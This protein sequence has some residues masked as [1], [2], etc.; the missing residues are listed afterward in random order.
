MPADKL[1]P[2]VP[3]P[4]PAN[5]SPVAFSSTFISMILFVLLFTP[6]PPPLIYLVISSLPSFVTYPYLHTWDENIYICTIN[7]ISCFS[8]CSSTHRRN[9][10]QSSETRTYPFL[11]L[12]RHVLSLSSKEARNRTKH[13]QVLGAYSYVDLDRETSFQSIN[14]QLH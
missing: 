12:P 9:W 3:V 10:T 8:S 11:C 6:P 1:V 7:S 2:A 5:I 13:A 14:V 4:A